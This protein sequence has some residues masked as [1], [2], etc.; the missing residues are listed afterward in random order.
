M[1]IKEKESNK[2]AF[3]DILLCGS[4]FFYFQLSFSG[5]FPPPLMAVELNVFF[6]VL[7]F[8]SVEQTAED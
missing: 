4:F 6:S 2:K 8:P 3:K 1:Q 5:P 7:I